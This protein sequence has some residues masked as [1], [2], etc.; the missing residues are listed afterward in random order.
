MD[1]AKSTI[2]IHLCQKIYTLQLLQDTGFI[3]AKRAPVPMDPN[4]SL[5]NTNVEVLTDVSGYRRLIGR[6]MCLAI[7]HP[8]LHMQSID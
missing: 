5:N 7:Y 4:I 2:G 8:N 6:L 1:I 3:S